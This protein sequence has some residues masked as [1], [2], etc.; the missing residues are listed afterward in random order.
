[1]RG[2]LAALEEEG[3][4]GGQWRFEIAVSFSVVLACCFCF[5]ITLFE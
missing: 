1:M 5:E 4:S 3:G 2:I